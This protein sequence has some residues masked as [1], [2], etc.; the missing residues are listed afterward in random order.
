MKSKLMSVPIPFGTRGI[1]KSS[2]TD[3]ISAGDLLDSNGC[4][5]RYNMLSKMPGTVAFCELADYDMHRFYNFIQ[6]DGSNLFVAYVKNTNTSHYSIVTLN[7][8]GID[9]TLTDIL[10]NHL[11][12]MFFIEG[13]LSTGK[14]GVFM[15]H[16]DPL[17]SY[18][19][20]FTPQVWNGIEPY[21]RAIGGYFQGISDISFNDTNP[22]TVT[23]SGT[24]LDFIE[25][26]Y[27]AGQTL[28]VQNTTNNNGSYTIASVTST[29]LTLIDADSLTTELNTSAILS[30][31]IPTDWNSFTQ[32][33]GTLHG[34]WDTDYIGFRESES[35][36]YTVTYHGTEFDFITLGYTVGQ[37]L[38][39][40]NA[41]KNNGTYTITAVTA[42]TLIVSEVFHYD[43]PT[44]AILSYETTETAVIAYPQCGVIHKGQ[45]VVWGVKDKEHTLYFSLATDNE[46]FNNLNSVILEVFPNEGARIAAAIS[47]WGRLF[48]FKYPY[49]IYWLDDSAI[50][51]SHWK[52]KKLSSSIG[53]A[54]PWAITSV[55]K[56]VALMDSNGYLHKLS[57]IQ[58][59]GDV[60]E[61]KF[62]PIQWNNYFESNW[63]SSTSTDQIYTELFYYDRFQEL[64]IASTNSSST[65]TIIDI[66]NNILVDCGTTASINGSLNQ[67][68]D[69]SNHPVIAFRSDVGTEM[70]TYTDQSGWTLSGSTITPVIDTHHFKFFPN[71]ERRVNLK[72]LEAVF[73]TDTADVSDLSLTLIRDYVEDTAQP[74][75]FSP[76]AYDP[77]RIISLYRK[78]WGD[79]KRLGFSIT[80]ADPTKPFN[81]LKL[82]IYFTVGNARP[83]T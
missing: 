75:T 47:V 38:R 19:T 72:R 40:Q 62:N 23:Y 77:V 11:N 8:Y 26:G 63:Q 9:K 59:L 37:T 46:D 74:I 51:P 41:P 16:F 71:D 78:I 12:D 32:W 35:A 49:G 55:E 44:S 34:H 45:L 1:N 70:I 25:R 68:F 39:V 54:G 36:P 56:D 21:S 22:D 67:A 30:F 48:I 2:N 13:R 83:E 82:I 61:S 80:Q 14:R 43:T 24:G 18:T 10:S 5:M 27:K 52:I 33:D 6:F 20:T 73:Q 31:G 53:M 79:C 60:E 66:K 57:T 81:L 76:A 58:A 42:T 50:D 69:S 7:S 29:T 15:F 4:V 3:L 28:R 17:H 65:A 64:W